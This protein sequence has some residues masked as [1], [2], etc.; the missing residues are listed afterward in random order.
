MSAHVVMIVSTV[1]MATIAV[2]A[3]IR[4][5][6]ANAVDR[7]Y[8]FGRAVDADGIVLG[9]EG[10]MLR[11]T[12]A[13][14]L[15]LLHGSGDSPQSMRY[16]GDR[17][18][19]A[20]YTVYAPL[21]PG[22]GRSPRA[23]AAAR[24]EE[25]LAAARAGLATARAAAPWVGVIGLS[26]GGALATRV[27]AEASDVRVLVLLAPYLITP[28]PVRRAAR[29]AWLWTLFVKY[30]G[31]GGEASVHDV[32]ARKASHAY[33]TFS[34]GAL[35]ALDQTATAG[36]QALASLSVPTLVINSEQD[37]RIPQAYAEKI[38]AEIRAPVE[39]HWVSQ[40]GH[41]ITV[42]YC[43]DTVADQVLAFLARHAD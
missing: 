32:G 5:R 21:L 24:A 33:G 15:L 20:G 16:F 13:R 8:L 38:I 30:V 12:N 10:F 17:L 37:N 42:D 2:V 18:N 43:K 40:C 9:A 41:V 25:F 31:G 36:R 22:H 39:S 23:F 11:G 14:G 27:A 1:T 29:T 4:R 26:M 35:R 6:N 7:V 34:A 3:I 19:A 28:E